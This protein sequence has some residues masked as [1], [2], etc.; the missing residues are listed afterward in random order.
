MSVSW[1][2]AIPQDLQAIKRLWD[3]QER[4]F[5][6]SG[7]P[8][9]RP[10][11]FLTP[12][13]MDSPF[14]PYRPPIV[15]ASVAEREGKIVALRITEAVLEVQ[16]VGDDREAIASL[17]KELTADAHLAKRMGFRSGW[18]LVPA[19]FAR[20]LGRFLKPWPHIRAWPGLAPVGINLKEIGE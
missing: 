20:V 17:G 11:L 13:A 16:F 18:G 1:R 14:Y 6:G 7:I 12:D 9:D 19:K 10:E 2:V 15:F 3:E 8:V 5:A 4:R